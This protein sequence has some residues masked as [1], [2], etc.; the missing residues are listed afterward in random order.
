MG[1]ERGREN[2]RDLR[3]IVSTTSL[4]CTITF[5][6]QT[7]FKS[8]LSERGGGREGCSP[9]CKFILRDFFKRLY[10]KMYR[11]LLGNTGASSDI[12]GAVIT[13]SSLRG[14]TRNMGTLS[15]GTITGVTLTG[16]VNYDVTLENGTISNISVNNLTNNGTISGGM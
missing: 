11:Q 6:I 12:Y 3:I 14:N 4:S 16:N 1:D 7:H 9:N 13:N 15:G 10:Y 8:I 2:R 5:F